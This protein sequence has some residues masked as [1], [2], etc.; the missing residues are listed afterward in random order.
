MRLLTVVFLLALLPVAAGWPG[1]VP[2]HADGVGWGALGSRIPK[3]LP[4]GGV[5][6]PGGVLP[7]GGSFPSG[8]SPSTGGSRL[9]S[10]PGVRSGGAGAGQPDAN[11]KAEPPGFHDPKARLTFT[12]LLRGGQRLVGK[13]F[14]YASV[15][16]LLINVRWQK[17]NTSARQRL[18]LY[19]PDGHLYQMF[20]TTLDADP[21]PV[22]IMLPVVGSWIVSA[23]LTGTW[24]AKVFID[25]DLQPVAADAFELSRP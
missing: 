14:D 5:A 7:P 23:T 4:P 12:A 17:V 24:C 11:C 8:G 20:T 19:S 15:K 3:S 22:D 25:D 2:A 6:P 18:A 9:P 1:G 16:D 21:A 13:Q 10:L